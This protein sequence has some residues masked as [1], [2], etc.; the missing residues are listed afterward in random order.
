M[1][2]P[3]RKALLLKA[4]CAAEVVKFTTPGAQ[5]L[6]LLS[7][8]LVANSKFNVQCM[9]CCLH[10]REPVL[11]LWHR[12]WLLVNYCRLIVAALLCVCTR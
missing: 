6:E 4:G 3:L 11:Q 7:T 8:A 12:P 2:L 10:H 9:C 1:Q 5:C